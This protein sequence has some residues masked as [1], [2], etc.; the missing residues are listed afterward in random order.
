MSGGNESIDSFSIEDISWSM[1]V[2][3]AV[4]GAIV[5][6]FL[7][8][9]LQNMGTPVSVGGFLLG[10]VLGGMYLYTKRVPSESVGSALYLVALVMLVTPF[11]LYF[12]RVNVPDNVSASGT[13]KVEN[14]KFGGDVLF[15]AGSIFVENL[16]TGNVSSIIA[17]VVW[18]VVFVIVAVVTAIAGRIVKGLASSAIQ[19]RENETHEA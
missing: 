5:G 14:V 8:Y 15:Q 17:L 2:T 9:A 1:A 13:L 4:M 10:F 6:G 3:S 11:S 19:K 18:T 12:L 7:A 16:S